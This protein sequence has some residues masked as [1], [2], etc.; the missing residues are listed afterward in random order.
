MA[1]HAL[2]RYPA[3]SAWDNEDLKLAGWL[4]AAPGLDDAGTAGEPPDEAAAAAELAQVLA[5]WRTSTRRSASARNRPRSSG[6][7]AG[8]LLRA[9]RSRRDRP[10][11]WP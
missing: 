1:V 8:E 4:H 9:R 11:R 10:A 6:P 7:R 2:G 5:G 3:S